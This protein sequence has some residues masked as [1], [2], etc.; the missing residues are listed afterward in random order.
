[1]K[2]SATAVCSAAILAL[3]AVLASSLPCSAESGVTF[4]EPPGIW[5]GEVGDGF[6]R[7]VQHAGLSLG[8]APTA[9]FA[10][11]REAHGLALARFDYGWVL[12]SP[13][14][15]GRFYGGNLSLI[16][17]LIAGAQYD[18]DA[19]YIVGATPLLRYTFAAG[20]P[21]LPYIEAGAGLTLT[22]I[23]EPDLGGAFQFNL[24]AGAGVLW[25]VQPRTAFSLSYRLMHLSSAGLSRPNSG[26]NA[27]L[28]SAGIHWHF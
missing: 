17:E 5:A 27:H 24:A 18:P 2:D 25:F 9:K 21:V 20:G 11:S 3:G 7:G 13:M 4:A 14:A 23:R 10:G 6:R 8:I 22:D 1:M 26:V 19:D 15:Q 12:T 28:I 16:A